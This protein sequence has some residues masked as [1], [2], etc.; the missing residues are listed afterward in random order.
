M[1]RA[2]WFAFAVIAAVTGTLT[3]MIFLWLIF[4]M[5]YG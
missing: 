3:G 1:M 4:G 2:L 5:I